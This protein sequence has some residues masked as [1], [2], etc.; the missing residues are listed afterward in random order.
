MNFA[1]T[2]ATCTPCRT[3]VRAEFEQTKDEPAM[4]AA[5]DPRQAEVAVVRRAEEARQVG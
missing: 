1:T 5:H 3:Q 4:R 2:L